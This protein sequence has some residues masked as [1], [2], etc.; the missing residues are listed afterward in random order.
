MLFFSNSSLIEMNPLHNTSSPEPVQS[1][2]LYSSM[3]HTVF[4]N[5][6][7]RLP[8]RYTMTRVVSELF[9]PT[10]T[11][12]TEDGV[13][14]R[15]GRVAIASN[16]FFTQQQIAPAGLLEQCRVL[17][18]KLLVLVGK[19][20]CSKVPQMCLAPVW[21][22]AG[23]KE[24]VFL[25]VDQLFKRYLSKTPVTEV[26]AAGVL[27]SIADQRDRRFKMF[28]SLDRNSSCLE[29]RKLFEDRISQGTE[30]ENALFQYLDSQDFLSLSNYF[31]ASMSRGPQNEVRSKDSSSEN[32]DI[33]L[34]CEQILAVQEK[35]KESRKG[36]AANWIA[37]TLMWHYS[38]GDHLP[39]ERLLKQAKQHQNAL[40]KELAPFLTI[41]SSVFCYDLLALELWSLEGE[42]DEKREQAV[43]RI[44][45]FLGTKSKELDLSSLCL[46]EL[47]PIFGVEG[48]F[49]RMESLDLS[50]NNIVSIPPSLCQACPKLS[51]ISGHIGVF[52][53]KASE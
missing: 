24:C 33:E 48:Y 38:Q 6:D 27:Q 43:M 40:L 18:D 51:R 13:Q 25:K 10:L 28:L 29:K 49:D 1:Q 39:L 4:E 14:T 53:E 35:I 9:M 32:L 46:R 34:L 16:F 15:C 3:A 22:E 31:L 23:D 44:V 42:S 47:P 36:S 19:H 50:L 5:L 7:T 17:C 11:L 20:S 30:G 52:S 45:H 21:N 12:D 37:L 41:Y 26:A 8:S 2:N